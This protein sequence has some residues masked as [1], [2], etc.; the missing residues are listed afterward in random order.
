MTEAVQEVIR[1]LFEEEF[2]DAITCCYYVKN[3]RSARVQEKCGFEFLRDSVHETTFGEKREAKC[4]LLT[5]E[6]Y[7]GGRG[8]R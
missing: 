4:N 7:A 6:K 2:L 3:N 5:R 8:Y 1:Y